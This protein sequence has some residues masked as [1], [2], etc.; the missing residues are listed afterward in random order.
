M[1]VGEAIQSMLTFGLLLIAVLTYIDAK[2]I[3]VPCFSRFG[4][5]I[6]QIL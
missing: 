5:V 3:T 6:M 1:S 4:T 2:K